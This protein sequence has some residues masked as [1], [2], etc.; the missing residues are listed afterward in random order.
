MAVV[1][2]E[3]LIKYRGLRLELVNETEANLRVILKE[4]EINR[5]GLALSGYFSHF[6]Y[7]RIQVFGKG[8][9]SFLSSLDQEKLRTCLKQFFKFKLNTL[10]FTHG[11][12]PPALIKEL[13]NDANIALLTTSLSTS[14]FVESYAD[15]I[16]KRLAPKTTM[17]GVLV[18][19]L[20]VGILLVG[21]SGV[22]KS[23]TALELI[24]RGHRLVADDIVEIICRGGSRLYGY[25]TD[26]IEH[27]MEIRGLGIINIKDL[28]GAGS[29]RKSKRIDL[30]LHI[31]DWNP[32]REYDRLGIE[33]QTEKILN[34][35]LPAMTIPVRPGRNLPILIETASKNHRLKQMGVHAAREFNN[36]L[37]NLM[38]VNQKDDN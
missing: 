14:R 37:L 9:H 17:H 34:V 11:N 19:V 5:P 4:R 15:Y 3:E 27:H 12:E 21:K 32:S 23:E 30:I 2:V 26:T 1:N 6:A 20:G 22:G 13:A 16:D 29:V 25:F 7:E 18:E 8:E 10:V 31:E 38:K 28:F 24:E 35:E 36:K 33:E